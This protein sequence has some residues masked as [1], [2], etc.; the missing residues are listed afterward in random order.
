MSAST[1]NDGLQVAEIELIE[2]SGGLKSTQSSPPASI[3][4]TA[5]PNPFRD[6]LTIDYN[7]SEGT[8]VSLSV[9]DINGRVV[10]QLVNEDQAEG[11]HRIAWDAMNSNYGNLHNGIYILKIETAID[12][13]TAKII[14]ME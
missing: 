10:R 6:G 5:S 8:H 4:L 1:G 14:Y 13:E 3:I 2:M 12:T 11:P 9:Y 7:L